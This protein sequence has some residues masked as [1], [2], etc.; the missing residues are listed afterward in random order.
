MK[1]VI[2]EC[3]IA[4]L[5]GTLIDGT[6]APRRV[7]DIYISDGKIVGIA[8][9]TGGVAGGSSDQVGW[10]AE[11]VIDATGK[12]VS[13]GFID[14]H[15]HDDR[16]VF[17]PSQILPKVSQGVTTVVTGNCGISIAPYTK[18]ET[19][20]PIDLVIESDEVNPAPMRFPTFA[21]YMRAL[22]MAPLSVNVAPLV[23]HS[24]LR[25]QAMQDLDREASDSEIQVM[26]HWV[27]EALQAGA[28]G[29]SSGVFYPPARAAT[30][31]ELIE[32]GRPLSAAG[33]H[34]VSHLRDE[35][36]NILEAMAEA[37]EIGRTLDIRVVLSHHKVVGVCNHGR[38]TET[39]A[40]ITEAARSQPVAL[41]CYPYHA[42]STVLRPEFLHR[43][44]RTKVTWSRPYPEMAGRMLDDV[45][46]EWGVTE[47]LAAERLVPA[48]AIYYAMDESDVQR[49]LAYEQTMIGSDGIAHDAI[50]HPRLWGTFPRVL[51]HYAR[52]LGLFS[53]ETAVHKMTGLP[54]A[55]FGMRDRGTVVPGAWADLVVFDPETVIDVANF[56][57]PT[58][59]AAGISH[60]LVNGKLTFTPAG[61]LTPGAGQALRRP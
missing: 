61:G 42:S 18:A 9:A 51:G 57:E 52:D 31:R 34:Y 15:T 29:L 55:N 53:L 35:G 19:P 48:G 16:A 37:F 27:D 32:V 13:P 45:A 28:W 26:R 44:K 30:T 47:H 23:G 50:P 14:V 36:N 5:G 12:V 17:A 21:Q 20:P 43:A 33:A 59:P 3:E 24:S 38:S 22:E 46:R 54:A 2:R 60:V 4:I 56:E 6:G 7:A 58:R 25:V 49:I 1:Q 40:A 11:S 39:L 10:K 8:S 41:D